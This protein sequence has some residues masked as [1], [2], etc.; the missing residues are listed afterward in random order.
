[1]FSDKEQQW[2]KSM[3]SR[4]DSP[5]KEVLQDIMETPPEI[6]PVC[7]PT[8]FTSDERLVF[9]KRALAEKYPI[10]VFADEAQIKIYQEM[11][12]EHIVGVPNSF[13]TDAIYPLVKKRNFINSTIEQWNK[14]T[15]FTVDD[16][17][18][19]FK[20]IY[21]VGDRT[22]ESSI[23]TLKLVFS[24]WQY[25]IDHSQSDAAV[26]GLVATHVKP[27]Y[28]D[29]ANYFSYGGA[30]AFKVGMFPGFDDGNILNDINRYIKTYQQGNTELH[31]PI[32]GYFYGYPNHDNAAID[33]SGKKSPLDRMLGCIE[34][35][36]VDHIHFRFLKNWHIFEVNHENVAN[37]NKPFKF[38]DEDYAEICELYHS[39][40][41]L[42]WRN[43][44]LVQILDKYR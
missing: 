34:H 29:T 9:L 6:S 4:A 33:Y 35:H 11:G 26:I 2:L 5:L 38:T 18:T 31:I 17:T 40:A 10:Y 12:F 24:I 25:Y 16:D 1:M 32:K 36:G 23:P 14:K 28:M 37:A 42:K 20:I 27:R 41:S 8:W 3:A 19:D 7:V 22:L 15:Y 44:K 39:T 21:K 43:K 30:V 13:R